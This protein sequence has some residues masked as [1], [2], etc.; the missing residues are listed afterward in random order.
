MT[1]TIN[2]E[3]LEA[4]AVAYTPALLTAVK[5]CGPFTGALTAEEYAVQTA[6][7]NLAVI[8]RAGVEAASHY[9][10]NRDA[11][12]AACSTLGIPATVRA[13]ED[14]LGGKP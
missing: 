9:Y 1:P 11:F 12:P 4:F 2:P 7:N 10:L 5:S 14:F 8:E 6:M 3:Q 13:I